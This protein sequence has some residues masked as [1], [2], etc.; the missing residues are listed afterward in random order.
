MRMFFVSLALLLSGC[1]AKATVPAGPFAEFASACQTFTTGARFAFVHDG[2]DANVHNRYD[3][4]V[5]RINS[6]GKAVLDGGTSRYSWNPNQPVYK[7]H[8]GIT[9]EDWTRIGGAQLSSRLTD[10]WNSCRNGFADWTWGTPD[11]MD[12]WS[13]VS[14]TMPY[15]WATGFTV[16][17]K[18]NGQT[19]GSLKS[20]QVF[21][22]GEGT[23]NGW[24][25]VFSVGLTITE[26]NVSLAP[27][28]L[29]PDL[30]NGVHSPI[31]WSWMCS[32]YAKPSCWERTG[33]APVGATT[34]LGN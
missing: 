32:P 21:P 11:V 23:A 10:L 19:P 16:R 4:W 17:L 33:W 31:P 3:Y 20:I 2:R 26:F 30:P 18:A 12:N 27:N 13:E 29:N 1:A 28:A 9:P 22:P 5:L 14:A 25:S 8:W 24:R 15:V 6:Q 34:M 7:D